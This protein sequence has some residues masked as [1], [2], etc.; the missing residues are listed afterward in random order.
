[1]MKILHNK[2]LK[3]YTTVKIG[4]YAKNLYIPESTDELIEIMEKIPENARYIL[5]GGSNILINDKKTFESIILV[6][7]FDK[8][9]SSVGDGKYYV[10]A[11]VRLQKL[12]NAVHLD[13][14]GGIEYL[15]SVPGLVGGAVVMN[16]GR[17]RQYGL[18]ISDYIIDVHVYTQGSIKV[19]KKEECAFGYRMS[20]FKNNKDYVI[21]GATFSFDK[22]DVN[23]LKKLKNER[24]TFSK[25]RQDNSGYNFGSVFMDN[26]SRI[27]SMLKKLGPGYKN[28][29]RFSRKTGNWILNSGEGTYDQ[30]IKL[31]NRVEKLHKIIGKKA[32]PEVIIWK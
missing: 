13:G 32:V 14:F 2:C 7:C 12:I 9:I 16:A 19:L 15:Y 3:Q 21:L 11:S 30:A 23:E 17:G 20:I 29:V 8:S 18:C 6:D 10:G 28:G 4:G 27:M 26:D 5:G 1:M 24:I 31:I 25:N 22:I